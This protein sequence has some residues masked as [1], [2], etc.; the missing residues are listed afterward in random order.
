MPPLYSS[1]YSHASTR[2]RGIFA[3]LLRPRFLFFSIVTL[4]ILAFHLSRSETPKSI[5][6]EDSLSDHSSS[7]VSA[8][9]SIPI[10]ET[11]K[12]ITQ[13]DFIHDQSIDQ[14]PVD[15]NVEHNLKE[16]DIQRK[17]QSQ[18]HIENPNPIKIPSDIS[19]EKTATDKSTE[20]ENTQ[21]DSENSIVNRETTTEDNISQNSTN[22]SKDEIDGVLASNELEQT[23]E[24]DTQETFETA[25]SSA[26]SEIAETAE[27]SETTET[28]E[29]AE[30]AE[31]TETPESTTIPTI[32]PEATIT[33]STTE[34]I[35]P[36]AEPESETF[37]PK[38]TSMDIV[39]AV[40]VSEHNIAPI[41]E[42]SENSEKTVLKNA[43]V[44]DAMEH[45][46]LS[47]SKQKVE[48]NNQELEK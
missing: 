26:T 22:D 13:D 44:S 37:E 17:A 15:K 46:I 18:P 41:T 32:T 10:P 8:H 38:P 3:V 30:T 29:T 4:A 27:T 14:S 20:Q 33:S 40:A 25:E 28:S 19:L 31:A 16:N 7:P 9:D 39:P 23:V 35:T 34:T 21:V 12:S 11:D 6:I 1:A 2:S 43:P 48:G 45:D 42:Q 5:N 47:Q 36:S 24:G